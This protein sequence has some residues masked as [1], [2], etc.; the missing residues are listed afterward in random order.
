M[1]SARRLP[2]GRLPPGRLPPGRLPPG[3]LPPGRLPPG[4]RLPPAAG[5]SGP[6]PASRTNPAAWGRRGSA[7]PGG[8]LA[9]VEAMTRPWALA[10][11]AVQPSSARPSPDRP[12]STSR[13]TCVARMSAAATPMNRPAW[14]DRS[15]QRERVLVGADEVHVRPGQRRRAGTL[16]LPVPV[17]GGVVVELRGFRVQVHL[18]R[19]DP[20]A[21]VGPPPLD[22]A[23]RIGHRVRGEH[24]PRPGGQAR[25]LPQQPR[26]QRARCNEVVAAKGWPDGLDPDDAGLNGA[27]RE[28]VSPAVRAQTVRAGGGPRRCG[29]GRCLAVRGPARG[30]GDGLGRRDDPGH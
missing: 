7:T 17:G 8:R 25:V 19:H 1:L 24:D 4:R 5:S 11:T 10:R 3:R 27:D 21:L 16:R 20:R 29:P 14:T 22:A 2:P 15:G 9:L 28:G 13:S 18:Q 12:G 23:G 30:P 6:G 26:H